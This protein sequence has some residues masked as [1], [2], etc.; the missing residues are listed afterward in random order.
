MVKLI[1]KNVEGRVYRTVWSDMKLG[2]EGKPLSIPSGEEFSIQV[3]GDFSN[4]SVIFEGSL[5]EFPSR[6]FT[7]TDRQENE[8]SLSFE[9]GTSLCNLVGWLRPR[10]LGGDETTKLTVLLFD[11]RA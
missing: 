8:V 2:D 5:E 3:V 6:W 10:I 9:G 1:R 7:L 11:R 4:A